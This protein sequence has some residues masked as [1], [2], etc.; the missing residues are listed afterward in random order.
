MKKIIIFFAFISVLTTTLIADSVD[1]PNGSII[2]EKIVNGHSVLIR[3]HDQILT[4]DY[5][6]QDFQMIVY[7]SPFDKNVKEYLTKKDQIRINEI[8]IIDS[9]EIWLNITHENINGYVLY[10][11]SNE[12]TVYDYYKDGFWQPV[13]TIQTG[14]TIWH[15][16]KCEASFFV[17]TNLNIRDTPG[18]TGLKIGMISATQSKYVTVNTIEITK[19]TDTIDGKNECWAKIQYGNITG[20]VFAGYLEYERGGPRFNTPESLFE[21]NLGQGV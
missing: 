20:W 12:R 10:E 18:L 19:E 1:I 3:K 11:Q 14:S 8:F 9:N 7:D 5:A 6:A 21:M 4:I 17:Y 13:D 2:E 16:L 15:T